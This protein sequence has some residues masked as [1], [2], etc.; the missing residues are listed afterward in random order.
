M[1]GQ[2]I[3]GIEDRKQRLMGIM[4]LGRSLMQHFTYPQ[5][6]FRTFR[7][8]NTAPTIFIHQRRT[9]RQA[10]PLNEEGS[11]ELKETRNR[12]IKKN[13]NFLLMLVI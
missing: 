10:D 9:T 12:S 8:I 13:I 11:P 1:Y 4:D 7:A 2:L 5:L 6:K 3:S